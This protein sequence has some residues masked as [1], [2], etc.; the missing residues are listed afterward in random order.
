MS[1]RYHPAGGYNTTIGYG[2]I[3]PL[4][5]LHEAANLVKLQATA[6]PGAG[7][8]TAAARFGKAQPAT[9][10]AVKH[11][12]A[13]LAGFGGGIVVGAVLLV[14]AF[15]LRARGRRRVRAGRHT[16]GVG[17]GPPAGPPPAGSAAPPDWV[18]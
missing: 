1:A 9:I 3:N 8:E 14:I 6:K 2:L 18:S 10:R 11:P 16:A 4:G 12:V 15:W 13:K 17:A 5:A 7:V